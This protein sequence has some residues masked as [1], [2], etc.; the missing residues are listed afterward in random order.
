MRN[1]SR[2]AMM[3]A[4]FG[5]AVIRHRPIPML[6]PPV[7]QMLVVVMVLIQRQGPCPVAKQLFVGA[8]AKHDQLWRDQL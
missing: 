6:H 4:V 1:P 2:L 7:R 8:A 3:M 5:M